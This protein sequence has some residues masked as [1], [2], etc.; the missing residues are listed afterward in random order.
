[1]AL[2]YDDSAPS[3]SAKKGL[4]YDAPS[5]GGGAFDAQGNPSPTLIP[6]SGKVTAPKLGIAQRAQ[7]AFSDTTG[8]GLQPPQTIKEFIAGSGDMGSGDYIARSAAAVG[9]AAAGGAAGVAEDLG[10]TRT[11]AN[12]LER[13]LRALGV[14]A[15]VAS[16]GAPESGMRATAEPP[17]DVAAAAAKT[18]GKGAA[19]GVRGVGSAVADVIGGIG[20]HTGGESLR[21]AFKAGL[22]GGE[23]SQLFLNA[24]RDNAPADSVVQT[25]RN[26]LGKM[27]ESRGAAYTS[28]MMDATGDA[29]QLS[30]DGV[31]DA[32]KDIRSAAQYKGEV[33]NPEAAAKLSEIEEAV[34][35]WEKN[36]PADFHTVQ[37][38]DALKQRIG[39]VLEST[40]PHTRAA[41]IAGQ[42][43]NAVKDEI[44]RQAPA[45]GNV[46]R[47][48]E[49]ASSAL[50]ELE[51]SL[52]LKDSWARKGSVDT[53]LRKLQSVM[54][55]NVNTNYGQRLKSVQS[56]DQL[57]GGKIMPQLAGQALSSLTPRGL[58]NLEA[59]ATGIVGLAHPAVLG[60]LPFQSPRLM[61]EAAHA[62]GAGGRTV[63][64]AARSLGGSP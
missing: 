35:K 38:F 36:D 27:R 14:A 48:Y 47:D 51:S 7:E 5:G 23:Q 45:Y 59:G 55:N 18:V 43:Y 56:L 37:G 63:R 11:N 13:D 33:I 62:L 24:L 46:M 25:A 44:V 58:G 30:F 52:S 21:Q 28:G 32:L 6:D 29:T 42:A 41:T 50:R 1:M 54:R 15:G 26:A 34:G 19:T 16:S 53:A 9:N 49:E 57:S 3:V 40:T 2:V 17:A 64:N 22:E 39:A 10:M 12:K 8:P 20:T 61:G 31:K 60:A 4:V